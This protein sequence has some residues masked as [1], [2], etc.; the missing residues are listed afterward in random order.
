MTICDALGTNL[1]QLCNLMP[2]DDEWMRKF[3]R[4]MGFVALNTARLETT[5]ESEHSIWEL[6]IVKQVMDNA[7]TNV[8]VKQTA[9]FTHHLTEG[10][11][12]AQG[13]YPQNQLK[14]ELHQINQNLCETVRSFLEGEDDPSIDTDLGKMLQQVHIHIF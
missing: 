2:Q 4:G 8:Y 13:D 9:L 10:L 11:K 6:D 1:Y 5:A 12:P 3:L 14:P 7:Y